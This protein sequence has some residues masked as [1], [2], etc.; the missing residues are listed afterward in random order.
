MI[1]IKLDE[2]IIK[3]Q[4]NFFDCPMKNYETNIKKLMNGTFVVLL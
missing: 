3:G 4:P 1:D 2:Y